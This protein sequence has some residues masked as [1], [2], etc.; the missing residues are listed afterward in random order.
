MTEKSI[1]IKKTAT[2]NK[3]SVKITAKPKKP[4]QKEEKIG[5]VKHYFHQVR[6]GVIKLVKNLA[7]GDEIN[8]KG[9]TTDFK[10]V[11]KSM[12]IDHQNILRAKA[13]QAVGLKVAKRVREGDVVYK[14]K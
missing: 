3:K 8:V 5:K 14:L 2:K 9:A 4:I 7:V 10:M 6:V 13:K 12:Q 1:I 11:V